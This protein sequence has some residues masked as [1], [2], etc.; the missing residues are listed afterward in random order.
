M[1]KIFLYVLQQ[2]PIQQIFKIAFDIL[3]K[4]YFR[5]RGLMIEFSCTE[6][7]IKQKK[8]TIFL[9]LTL[10]RTPSILP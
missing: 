2:D 4:I 7:P 10:D 9:W 1:E 5:R 8:I 3:I 6:N